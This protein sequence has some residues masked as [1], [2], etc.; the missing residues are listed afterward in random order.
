MEK[1]APEGEYTNSAEDSEAAHS[2]VSHSQFSRKQKADAE[3]YPSEDDWEKVEK[4][5]GTS[6]DE[7]VELSQ[8]S[9]VADVQSVVSSTNDLSHS[10]SEEQPKK[11]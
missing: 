5:D 9:T 7:P 3:E 11:A 10:G 2:T 4:D 8:A 6:D 1:E